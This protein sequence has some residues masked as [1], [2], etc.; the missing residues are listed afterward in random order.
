M[1]FFCMFIKNIILLVAV[2]H[3]HDSG[4][5]FLSLWATVCAHACSNVFTTCYFSFFSCCTLGS[6]IKGNLGK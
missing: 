1:L 4:V 3:V 6:Q 5:I 2:S